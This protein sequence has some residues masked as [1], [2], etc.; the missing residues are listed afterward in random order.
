MAGAHF[1]QALMVAADEPHP[2]PGEWKRHA[3]SD[4]RS[5]HLPL[6]VGHGRVSMMLS[7][8]AVTA[9]LPAE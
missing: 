7:V 2:Q 9:I 5:G 6:L 4:E 3:E 1:L 8:S